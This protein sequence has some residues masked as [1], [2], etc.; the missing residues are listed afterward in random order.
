MTSSSEKSLVRPEFPIIDELIQIPDVSPAEA[1]QRLLRVREVL[2]EERQESESP[3]SIDGN[4]AWYTISKLV[5]KAET[6]PAAQQYKLLDFVALLQRTK[7]IDPATGE[8]PTA[9]DLKLWNELPYLSIYLADFYYFDF[10]SKYARQIDE[11]PQSEYPPRD[12]QKWENRNAFMAQLTA[13]ANYF[14]EYMDASLYAFYS[15]RSA[16]EQGPLI[17]EAVRT[18]CIWY[19]YAGQR[20]WENCQ[21]Q[22]HFG[23]DDDPPPRRCM[24]ME[25]WS[26]WKD[27]L[28]TAQL[29]FPRKSTQEMMRKALEEIEKAEHRE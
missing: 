17:E 5:E 22:R 19:I 29:E 20:V 26:L 15:C 4:H 3:S 9:V 10:K 23:N 12:L 21:A 6:T 28:K 16:F 18:A 2:H 14:C 11:D 13:R 27:R 25:K 8:Q 1:V 7:V 24:T